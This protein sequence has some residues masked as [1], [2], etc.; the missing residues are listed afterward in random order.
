MIVKRLKKTHNR[1]GA[2]LVETAI[3]LPVFFLIV[4]GIVEF[5]RAMMVT[6]LLANACREGARLAIV[7]GYTNNDVTDY[8]NDFLVDTLK[9]N[10]QHVTV[11]ITITPATGNTTTGNDITAA[12][13]RDLI[14]VRAD[15][16]FDE[17][18]YIAGKYLAG[19]TLRSETTMLRE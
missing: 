16:P 12:Q 5:G 8:V 2:V 18:S 17:V 15:V 10:T 9:V 11:S 14:T 19:K 13:R 4:F 7:D 3:A 6:Q 1:L